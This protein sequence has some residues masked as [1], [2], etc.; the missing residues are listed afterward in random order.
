MSGSKFVYQT[1]RVQSLTFM[2]V[3]DSFNLTKDSQP[4]VGDLNG[5][6]IDDLIFNNANDDQH[7]QNGKGRLNVAIFMPGKDKYDVHNFKN[8]MVDEDCGG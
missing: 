4:F 5:D 7:T 2:E 8:A 3:K 6:M 1:G